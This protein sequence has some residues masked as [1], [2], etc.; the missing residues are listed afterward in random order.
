MEPLPDAQLSI[1]AHGNNV[2]RRV[3]RRYHTTVVSL[4]AET[5]KGELY[6]KEILSAFCYESN[7]NCKY[8][9]R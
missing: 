1:L 5:G 8:S 7:G 6:F 9:N 3:G 2:A 4:D